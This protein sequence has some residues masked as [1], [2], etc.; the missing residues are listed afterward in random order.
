MQRWREPLA[1]R[2]LALLS[3]SR[4]SVRSVI[5]PFPQNAARTL[6]IV[7]VFHIAIFDFPDVDTKAAAA[8]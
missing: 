3:H 4:T 1:A 2:S 6:M 5:E 7:R 8:A